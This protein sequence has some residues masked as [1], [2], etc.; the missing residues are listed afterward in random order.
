MSVISVAFHFLINEFSQLGISD[1]V[2]F[3]YFCFDHLCY[4]YVIEMFMFITYGIIYYCTCV[5][6]LIGSSDLTFQ[7]C[8]LLSRVLLFLIFRI[9]PGLAII[10]AS[11][12]CL[13]MSSFEK[14]WFNLTSE[15][16]IE[17]GELISNFFFNFSFG[18][19]ASNL[20][21]H[22]F[23]C[24]KPLVFKAVFNGLNLLTGFPSMF[25]KW[26]LNPPFSF[27]FDNFSFHSSEESASDETLFHSFFL[28]L[29]WLKLI[30]E[31]EFLSVSYFHSELL[32][33]GKL[34]SS[35][36]GLIN[37]GIFFIWLSHNSLN[38]YLSF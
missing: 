18:D 29:Y 1:T 3:L 27:H 20:R 24:F 15:F 16:T 32:K 19:I 34:L 21:F 28:W 6:S 13:S 23:F 31:N 2:F 11:F 35:L 12:V 30:L 33:P 9:L 26:I 10:E 17:L 22:H 36:L 25:E 5:L 8:Q 4:F 7:S 14:V 38:C 37:E